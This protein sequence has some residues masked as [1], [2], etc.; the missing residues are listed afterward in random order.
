MPNFSVKRSRGLE[1]SISESD[2]KKRLIMSNQDHPV[3]RRRIPRTDPFEEASDRDD[4]DDRDDEKEEFPGVTFLSQE[5]RVC[6][7][8]STYEDILRKLQ[9]K[10][11]KQVIKAWL[12][13]CH[14]S[15]QASFP[16]NGGKDAK[17]RPDFDPKNPGR[18]S[19]P[20]YWPVQDGWRNGGGSRHREPDHI[21]KTGEPYASL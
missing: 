13:R 20:D 12:R 2:A 15:K 6:N 8:R 16:Y 4:L 10:G 18:D 17:L 21:Y 1:D 9:Q 3:K 19:A 11:L 14:H 7:I 5:V